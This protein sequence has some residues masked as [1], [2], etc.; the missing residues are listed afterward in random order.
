MATVDAEAWA[1][2]LLAPLGGVS[3]WSFDAGTTY[4]FRVQRTSIQVDV[5]ASSKKRARDRADAALQLLL[6]PSNHSAN[7]GVV[8]GV[9]VIGGPFW[10]PDE[11]GAPRYVLRVN[12]SAHPQ[13][14]I[15]K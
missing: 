7:N 5:R 4:P 2:S 12:V 14:L 13:A 1:Y 3:L 8:T 11:N 15:S 6:D 9:D 10:L